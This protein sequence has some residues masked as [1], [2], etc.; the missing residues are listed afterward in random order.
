MKFNSVKEGLEILS[1]YFDIDGHNI[2]A[3]H[4]EIFVYQTSIPVSIDDVNRLIM[5]GWRQNH[6]DYFEL[7]DYCFEESWVASI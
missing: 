1:K 4:D 7:E 6:V 5:L 3:E 2:G